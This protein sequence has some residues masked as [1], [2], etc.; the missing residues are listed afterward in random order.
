MI[1]LVQSACSPKGSTLDIYAFNTAIH[2][3]THDK[4]INEKTLEQ[5]N[6]Q[7]KTL[8]CELDAHDENS[9]VYAINSSNVNSSVSVSDDV[10]NLINLAEDYYSFSEGKFNFTLYP[11]IDAWKFY[12]YPKLNFNPPSKEEINQ[13][14]QSGALRTENILVDQTNKTITKT[15]EHTKI[16]LGGLAKG[17]AVDLIARMLKE[18]GH[19]SGY[20]NVG[21]SSLYLLDVSSLTIKHPRATEKKPT[22]MEIFGQ[23]TKNKAVST[24]GDYQRYY[25]YNGEIFSHIIDGEKYYPS[26]TSIVS[27][28]ILGNNATFN[29]AMTT[30]LCCFDYSPTDHENSPLIKF[31]NK[32]ISSNANCT[33]F[34]I[35]DDGQNKIILTNATDNEYRLLDSDYTLRSI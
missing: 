31:A 4:K 9:F 13:I 11:I 12:D 17:Y 19:T 24:S 5:L 23:G 10:I 26:K 21:G 22:V 2:I 7:I 27:A 34:L 35:Y 20:V 29:D 14:V 8:D 16:D 18:D 32:L 28:T 15:N 6:S 1:L 3:E 33:I 30:A 25:E